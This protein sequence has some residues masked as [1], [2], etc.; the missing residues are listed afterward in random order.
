MFPTFVFYYKWDTLFVWK[1][2]FLLLPDFPHSIFYLVAKTII[3][4]VIDKADNWNT[5]IHISRTLLDLIKLLMAELIGLMQNI[6]NLL[7]TVG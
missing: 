1:G 4:N 7:Y 2:D 5:R 6:R 3:K